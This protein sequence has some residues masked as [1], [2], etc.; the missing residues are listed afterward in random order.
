MKL[1]V[2]LLFCGVGLMLSPM[3]ARGQDDAPPDVKR[4]MKELW[5]RGHCLLSSVY[6]PADRDAAVPRDVGK[7]PVVRPRVV[8]RQGL[9]LCYAADGGTLWAA[10]DQTLYQV[11]AAA[12]KVLKAFDRLAGLPDEPI[13]SIAPAGRSVWLATRGH[14]ARLDVEVGKIAPVGDIRFA[15]GRLA[16]GQSGAWLISDAGAYR[17]APGE[18]QW[19]PLPDFPGRDQLAGQV[20]RGFWSA[21]WHKRM[22]VLLPSIFAT[23]DGVYVVCANRLLHCPAGGGKWKEISRDVWRASPAGRTVWALTTGGAVR[24]DPATGKTDRYQAG[25]GPASGRPVAMAA[26]SKAFLLASQPDYDGKAKRFV[27]GGI[28]RLDLAGGEWTVTDE[29]DGTDVRFI[30]AVLADGDEAWATCILYEKVSQLGAHPGMAHVKRWRPEADGLGLLHYS[31]GKWTLQKRKGLKTDQRWVM[32]QKGTV[33]KDFIGPET[34]EMMCRCGDRLW[35]VYRIVPQHYYAG[36][37]IS[38]GCL[39]ERSAGQW[40][41]RF[42]VRTKE[43]GF[44]GEQPKVMLISHSHGHRIVL[45]DGHPI[46]L[47]IEE[48][49]GRTWVITEG[50]LFVYDPGGDRFTPVLRARARLYWRATAAAAGKECVWFGG[51]AGTISRLDRKTGRLELIGV[52]EGRKIERLAVGDGGVLAVTGKSDAVL[53][54]SL[55]SVPKLPQG[56]V[57]AFDGQRWTASSGRATR[58]AVPYSF[59]KSNYLYRGARRVAFLKG[60]FRPIVLCEDPLGGRLWLGTYAGVAGMPLPAAGGE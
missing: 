54:V 16:A 11:D 14:L 26:G 18:K 27:G 19:R 9:L 2:G 53:P 33:K 4:A 43:L 59:K 30:T 24:Y 22:R 32:G 36:Y 57:L 8:G 46:A 31:G 25:K 3:A 52:A 38:A 49:A 23:G 51:D 47:G 42:D 58:Q 17:L 35:G 29:V 5:R 60:I 1:Q 56:D 48:L 7:T 39:A 40:Q 45:A 44:E 41:G 6:K 10:D 37:F 13:Q 12:G 28:S 55:A 21:V 34:V 50:G 20:R 15:M